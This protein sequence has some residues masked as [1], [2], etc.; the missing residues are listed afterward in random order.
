MNFKTNRLPEDIQEFELAGNTY[1]CVPCFESCESC[2]FF[3][4]TCDNLTRPECIS[5]KRKDKKSIIF[6]LKKYV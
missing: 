5:E 6:K 2:A 1:I 3:K 4:N